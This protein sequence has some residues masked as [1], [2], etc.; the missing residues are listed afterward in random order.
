MTQSDEGSVEPTV[1]LVLQG[2]GALGAYHMGAYQALN[3]CGLDPHWFCGISIGAVNAAILA[4]NEPK[5][6]LERLQDFW[7]G[8]SWPELFAPFG[9]G[10]VRS[11]FN[12]ASFVQALTFGQPGFFVP[13]LV[14]PFIAL[15]ATPDKVSFYDTGPLRQTLS[16]VV[17]FDRINGQH[18]QLSLGVTDVGS[19]EFSFFENFGSNPQPI[20]PE[21]VVASGSLPPG[22]PATQIGE[23]YYWDGGCVSN[24]ALDAVLKTEPR[25]HSIVFVIDLWDAAGPHPRTL[26]DVLW[27]QKQI[28]YATRTAHHIEA[29]T[30]KIN[31]RH[32]LKLLK[33]AKAPE[34]GDVLPGAT[35]FSTDNR[36]DIVHI[37]YHPDAD[38]IPNSDA[39]FSRTSIE[40]RRAAGY[41]DM[42]RAIEAKPW[43]RKE[44]PAHVGA[45]VHRVTPQGVV[46]LPEHTFDPSSGQPA[47]AAELLHPR[48]SASASLS[49]GVHA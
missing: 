26:R 11:F 29:I 27:R 5:R 38:Q 4:G 44:R 13:R 22:F 43:Y 45:L 39:E 10:E 42:R 21:H 23:H 41:R 18:V 9:P 36:L 49:D 47:A 32:A 24:S 25:G 28:Q 33:R 40:G 34:A 1:I 8:V 15:P 48:A 12:A 19:G 46:T 17:D 35:D 16:R 2:G 6:R 7:H 3:E 37:I 30:T 14:N 20:G 31:L